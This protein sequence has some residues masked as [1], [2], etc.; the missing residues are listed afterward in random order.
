MTMNGQPRKLCPAV[1][2]TLDLIANSAMR[3]MSGIVKRNLRSM[4][5]DLAA[6][7]RNQHDESEP[8]ACLGTYV[9][10]ETK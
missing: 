10:S 8:K 5:V 6:T 1:E 9:E 2:L 3:S 4:S 7:I